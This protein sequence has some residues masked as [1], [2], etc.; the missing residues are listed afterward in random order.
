ME[1]VFMV[2]GQSAATAAVHSIYENTTVQ[3]IDYSRLK[4]QFIKDGQVLDFE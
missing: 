2:M 3:R 4:E 1:P